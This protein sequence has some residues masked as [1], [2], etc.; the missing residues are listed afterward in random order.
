MGPEFPTKPGDPIK[1]LDS[2]LDPASQDEFKTVGT[3]PIE[4]SQPW[5]EIIKPEFFSQSDFSERTPT[6]NSKTSIR[7]MPE[8]DSKSR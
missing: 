1:A 5:R 6:D 8:L 2:G 7:L 3:E 4:K